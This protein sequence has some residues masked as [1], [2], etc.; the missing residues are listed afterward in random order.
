M[1][2]RSSLSIDC[3]IEEEAKNIKVTVKVKKRDSD[4][5]T[6]MSVGVYI[7]ICGCPY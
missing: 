4:G 5:D 7:N 2:Y 6:A 1:D 3:N